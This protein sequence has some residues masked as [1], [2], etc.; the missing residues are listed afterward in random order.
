MLLRNVATYRSITIREIV[1]AKGT[2]TGTVTGTG[3]AIA[4][5]TV[6]GIESGTETVIVTVI[7]TVIE[8]GIET[9][10]ET[11]TGPVTRRKVRH[12]SIRTS[13]VHRQ[14][15]PQRGHVR[16]QDNNLLDHAS[17]PPLGRARSKRRCGA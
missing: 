11:E 5:A 2:E 15:P 14:N 9:A 1:T 16:S 8:S 10:T 12:S 17:P 4:T 3:I 7:V 13:A 6:T